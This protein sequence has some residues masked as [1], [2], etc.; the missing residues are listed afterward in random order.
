MTVNIKVGHVS[1]NVNA[2]FDLESNLNTLRE[3]SRIGGMLL[4]KQ[5]FHHVKFNRIGQM[6]SRDFRE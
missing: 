3:L 2:T 6:K 4:G 5:T 1:H